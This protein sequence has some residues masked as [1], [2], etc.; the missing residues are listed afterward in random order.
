MGAVVDSCKST[1][2]CCESDDEEGYKQRRY[3]K[4]IPSES[5]SENNNEDE[6]N[7]DKEEKEEKKIEDIDNI[8]VDS[9]VLFMQRHQS[10]WKF[11]E[12]L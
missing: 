2:K 8:K 10:P 4:Y 9:N 3:S 6:A 5:E 1:I 12:A 7:S 11:Y